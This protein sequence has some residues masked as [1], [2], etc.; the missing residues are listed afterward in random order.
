MHFHQTSSNSQISHSRIKHQFGIW[1]NL[2]KAR[3]KK[4]DAEDEALIMGYLLMRKRRNYQKR[5]QCCGKYFCC[6]T[7][8]HSLSIFVTP[9]SFYKRSFLYCFIKPKHLPNIVCSFIFDRLTSKVADV[10]V[11]FL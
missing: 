3:Q 10:S 11:V 8:R 9:F 4:M 2:R 7:C 5:K 6:I 1:S